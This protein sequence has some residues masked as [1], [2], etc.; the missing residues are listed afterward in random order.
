MMAK[1]KI[2]VQ[3]IRRWCLTWRLTRLAMVP[4]MESLSDSGIDSSLV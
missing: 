2:N 3:L 4:S 1:M